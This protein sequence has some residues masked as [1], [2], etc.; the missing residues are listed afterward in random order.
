M[1]TD[2]WLWYA[3]YSTLNWL[4]IKLSSYVCLLTFSSKN[5]KNKFAD[6]GWVW[7]CDAATAVKQFYI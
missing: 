6:V 3:L 7:F 1:N 2:T 5:T 4:I